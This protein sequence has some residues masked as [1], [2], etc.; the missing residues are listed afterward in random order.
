MTPPRHRR[1][2]RLPALLLGGIVAAMALVVGGGSAQ[3]SCG[4]WLDGHG[5]AGVHGVT[6]GLDAPRSDV[7]PLHPPGKRTCNGPSC[8]GAPHLPPVS[9]DVPAIQLDLERDAILARDAPDPDPGAAR[10]PAV[11]EPRSTAALRGRPERPPR[12]V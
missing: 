8:G 11:G 1:V 10:M 6:A 7:T 2:R 5:P 3:A 12:G 9:P 4:D